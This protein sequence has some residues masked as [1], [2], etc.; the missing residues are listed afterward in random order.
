[1]IKDLKRYF[2]ESDDNA[3]FM[4]ICN[5][6]SSIIIASSILFCAVLGCVTA[7][8]GWIGFATVLGLF[9]VSFIAL[10]FG[11]NDE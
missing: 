2:D 10:T 5:I 3:T 6:I 8:W 9:I 4:G 7:L 1:M 11:L